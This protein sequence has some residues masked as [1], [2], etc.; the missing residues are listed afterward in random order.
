MASSTQNPTHKQETG[1]L[2]NTK[3]VRQMANES[4][5]FDWTG[6]LLKISGPVAALLLAEFPEDGHA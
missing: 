1:A 5:I 4:E 3:G 6:K 2:L